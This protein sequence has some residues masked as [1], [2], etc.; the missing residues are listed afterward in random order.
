MAVSPS[1]ARAPSGPGQGRNVPRAQPAGL[2]SQIQK[3]D[4]LDSNAAQRARRIQASL[5]PAVAGVSCVTFS[6]K[7]GL[8][9]VCVLRTTLSA[10]LLQKRSVCANHE[11]TNSFLAGFG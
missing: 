10:N 4:W 1:F 8:A 11:N 7:R 6:Q 3:R 9:V 5:D 2:Q